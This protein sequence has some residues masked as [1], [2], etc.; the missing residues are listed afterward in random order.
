[1]SRKYRTLAL[2]LSAL[3]LVGSM[4]LGACAQPA[5]PTTAAPTAAAPTAV[6]PTEAVMT[7]APAE[8][9]MAELYAA[10]QAEGMLTTIALPHDWCNYE[11]VFNGFKA[12][13]PGIEVNELDPGAG[14]GE[15]IGGDQSQQGQPR[16]TGPGRDR[17]R[18]RLRTHSQGRGS[19]PAL[20][21]GDLGRNP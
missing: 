1:M 15:E 19:H 12:K 18:S 17:R 6:P 10:A 7:E 2:W 21:G 3:L 16:P 9:P 14:S 20:Q 5:A 13:Y 11:A 4:L 8:D